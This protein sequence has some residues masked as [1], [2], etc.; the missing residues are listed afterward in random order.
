MPLAPPV[1]RPD[2]RAHLSDPRCN[3]GSLPPS[4]M[5][6]RHPLSWFDPRAHVGWSG[7][8]NQP[9]PPL[10]GTL[11]LV[12]IRPKIRVSSEKRIEL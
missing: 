2:P 6:L 8:Y 5:H 10:Q 3:V 1:S 11:P 12:K 4:R 7:L 9:L